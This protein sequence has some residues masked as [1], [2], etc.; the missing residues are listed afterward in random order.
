MN[1]ALKG[2]YIL[3]G[4]AGI[5]YYFVLWRV[6]RFGLSLSAMWPA[7]G[8]LSLLCARLCGDS[9]VP[10]WVHV[11]WR[12]FVCVVVAVALIL[13][14]LVVSGM[15]ASAPQKLDYL[16][17]LG[18]R[19]DPDGPSPALTRRIDAATACIEA[20]P[21]MAVIATGGQGRDEPT[22]EARC[23]RDELVKRGI[24]PAR[25]LMEERSTSTVENLKNAMALMDDPSAAVGILTNNFHVFRAT[26]IAKK[27]GLANSCGVAAEYTG[28]TRFHY[29]IRE[30]V[31]IVVERLRGNL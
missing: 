7:L 24:D 13:E 10:G 20:H 1:R 14:G 23:I 30:A 18:A 3:L 31:C 16:I 19:V 26:A 25:I 15:A 27:L 21:G 28:L 5:A 9:R 29:M 11:A 6:S 22:S 12:S 4:L 17:V 2:F 8:V